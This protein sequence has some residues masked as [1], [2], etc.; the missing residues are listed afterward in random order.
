MRAVKAAGAGGVVGTGLILGR[1]ANALLGL[2]ALIAFLAVLAVAFAAYVVRLAAKS[3]GVVE[4]IAVLRGIQ[5]G[6][7]WAP[8]DRPPSTGDAEEGPVLGVAQSTVS[9]DRNRSGSRHSIAETQAGPPGNVTTD[10]DRS[11]RST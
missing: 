10:Q 5:M 1:N 9:V 11:R 4:V 6:P 7:R 3:P 2:L 8:R